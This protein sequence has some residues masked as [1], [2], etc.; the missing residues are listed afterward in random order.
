[1]SD[2]V[3]PEAEALLTSEPLIAHLATCT[4]NDPH[5]APLWYNYRDGHI[6]IV[7]TGQKLANIRANPR[8]ALSVQKDEYG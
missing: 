6:E 4:E 2:T 5:V 8:V 1:M 3:P 7:T